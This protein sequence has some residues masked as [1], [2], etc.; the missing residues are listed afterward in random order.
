[1]KEP[2]AELF[3]ELYDFAA[4]A[5]A[6][7]GYVYPRERVDASGL[8][9]WVANLVRQYG[10]LPEEARASFQPSLDRTL[11]RAIHSLVPLLGPDHECVRALEALVQGERPSSWNDFEKEK[12]EKAAGRSR[13]VSV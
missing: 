11:G 1:M 5:G 4:S 8:G 10:Q 6:L 12:A 3:K 9:D 13:T 2:K 7:E